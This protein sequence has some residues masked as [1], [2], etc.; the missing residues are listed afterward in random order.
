MK[1]LL[2]SMVL[3]C[4]FSTTSAQLRMSILGGPHAASVKENNSLPG[5]QSQMKPRFSARGGLNLGVLIDI[6][7]SA[8]NKLSLSPGIFYM[9]KGRKY[10]MRNDTLASIQT[11]TISAAYNLAVNYIDIPFNLTYRLPL[12]K[13]ANFMVSAGPYAGFFYSG[14]QVFETRIYST[15]SFSDEEVKV[16]S[17]KEQG[18]VK[19]FN[20]GWNARVGFELGSVLLTGFMSESITSFYTA[21]YEGSFKHQVRGVSL[22]FWLNKVKPRAKAPVAPKDSDKDGVVDTNDKCPQLAGTVLTDGCPDAD[23]DGIADAQDKCADVPGKLKYNGC[24][25]PDTDGDGMNDEAD[26]CPELAGTPE[27]NGCPIPDSDGDGLND[28]EDKCPQQAGILANSGCPE[29]KKEVI[30]KVT[31]AAKNIFF[32]AA[33]NQLTS[34]SFEPLDEVAQLLAKNPTARLNIEG[35]TDSTGSIQLNQQLSQSRADAVKNYL[36][37]KGIDPV[38]LNASGYGS[39]RPIVSN[40]SPEGRRKNRRVELKLEGENH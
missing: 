28:V 12:G 21:P 31:M 32:Q 24:P 37:Q 27:F 36:V 25:V 8:D 23:A 40:A 11:D 17:G 20:A 10:Y 30:E 33:S 18:K 4:L 13:K 38:R 39:S 9:S 5:W 35:H 2:I 15:N 29:I 6:P 34:S 3:L 26:T 7:I 1:Y 16:E 19:T 14:K 22:G